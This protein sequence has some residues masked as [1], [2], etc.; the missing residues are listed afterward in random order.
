[1]SR[2]YIATPKS[3]KI[4]KDATRDERK[5]LLVDWDDVFKRSSDASAKTKEAVMET[6]G[7]RR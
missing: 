6:A 2:T 3:T 1:M 4:L 7:K 5:G